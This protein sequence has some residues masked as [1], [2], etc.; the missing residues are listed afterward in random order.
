M[1]EVTTINII[2]L[3]IITTVLVLSFLLF[4]NKRKEIVL[5]VFTLILFVSLLEIFVRL[6]FPLVQE[7]DRMFEY[8]ELLG[9]RFIPNKRGAIIYPGEARHYVKTNSLGFRDDQPPPDNENIRKILVFG[10]SFVSNISVGDNE[11]FTEVM[12]ENLQ[13]TSV[14]NMGVNGYGQVQQYLL[15]N[16]LFEELNPDLVIFIIY[17]RND[18]TENTGGF[19]LYPQPYSRPSA[20][21]DEETST[22]Q[23]FPPPPVEPKDQLTGS[24]LHFYRR[25]QLYQFLHQ[26]LHR[27]LHKIKVEDPYSPSVYTPPEL[28]LCRKTLPEDVVPMYSLTEQLLLKMDRFGRERNVPVFF[29][30]APSILQVED[31]LWDSIL[32]EF[33]ANE[34]DFDRSLPNQRF[35]E[36]ASRNDLKMF[37]LLPALRMASQ[38]GEKVYHPKEQHWTKTGNHVVAHALL[39]LIRLDSGKINLIDKKILK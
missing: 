32:K 22:L 20:K 7:H 38:K 14:L 27:L 5:L 15:L 13:N 33:G 3:S 36:F 21:W 23:F 12:E 31:G 18:L 2:A 26:R 6:F 17:I 10:D 16:K 25:I 34:E 24:F 1:S 8:D 29:V 28:Y 39:E 9:W 37:D 4:R 35:V 11:V 30:I 19:W